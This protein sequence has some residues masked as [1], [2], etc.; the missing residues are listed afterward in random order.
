MILRYAGKLKETTLV[1][2]IEKFE[3]RIRLCT[4]RCINLKKMKKW[5]KMLNEVKIE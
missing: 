1:K 5:R 2:S 3:S 4:K